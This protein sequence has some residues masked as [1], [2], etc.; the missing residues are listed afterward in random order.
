MQSSRA[1]DRAK[2][3]EEPQPLRMVHP[4]RAVPKGPADVCLPRGHP[5][6]WLGAEDSRTPGHHCW[7]SHGG[8]P[9]EAEWLG[10]LQVVPHRP[11]FR[12]N[13]VS[14]PKAQGLGLESPGLAFLP[15]SASVCLVGDPAGPTPSLRFSSVS[16]LH[17]LSVWALPYV[18]FYSGP[19]PPSALIPPPLLPELPQPHHII[20][21]SAPLDLIS[22][23]PLPLFASS[24]NSFTSQK[25][26]KGGSPLPKKAQTKTNLEC[27][28]KCCVLLV[29]CVSLWPAACSPALPVC[30]VSCP[31][32]RLA[33]PA[34]DTEF[35]AWVFGDGL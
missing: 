27:V 10:Q 21:S 6:M 16:A 32:A 34:N 17:V 35:S 19:S 14:Y 4:A 31:P 11:S 24:T 8:Q 28:P 12:T 5:Q 29:A 33:L 25:R 22:F 15:P 30:C 18:P 7:A 26:K 23:Q 13:V 2:Q 3:A 1:V 9:E 20:F